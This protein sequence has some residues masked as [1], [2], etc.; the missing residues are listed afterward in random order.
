MN[1]KE[2]RAANA[3]LLISSIVLSLLIAEVVLHIIGIPAPVFSG[4]RNKSG[5][6]QTNQLGFRGQKID[7]TD[8]DFVVVLVGDSQV[9]ANALMFDDLPERRLEYY[10]RQRAG[11]K[12]VKAYSI[13]GVGFGQDQE[14]LILRKYLETY[15]A[16]MVV[17]WL[18][19]YNDVWNNVFPTHWPNNGWP[20]PTFWLTNGKLQGPS[21]QMG[22]VFG[23]SK[24]KLFAL[25]NRQFQFI[26]RDGD[27]EKHLPSAYKPLSF[28][29]GKA[30]NDWQTKWDNHDELMRDENLATEKSHFAISLTPASPRTLYG[31]EL[32]RLLLHEFEG[33][34][35]K[36][37]GK[38]V[39]F[40]VK[41]PN[42]ADNVCPEDEVVHLLNGKY[43]K[44]S[45]KQY[46]DN[47]QYIRAGFSSLTIPLTIAQW[48]VD[49]RDKHHL[50]EQAT[51]QVMNDLAMQL[52]P[53]MKERT[54]LKR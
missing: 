25:A 4:W 14:L 28:Y 31:R 50:N 51:D 36:N 39:I 49:Q 37:K 32:T 46:S 9:A 13:G 7:Y 48:Q 47:W 23:W 35:T 43:Y 8:N 52:Q 19:P 40:D 1:M 5:D 38:F 20:K 44:T 26:D 22:E 34:V 29:E 54:P 17:L 24:F 18:T 12:N 30:C 41:L 6:L 33:L 15:R 16:D 2:K 21:E 42:D 53:F 27:W 3:I 10:L 11:S 45:L